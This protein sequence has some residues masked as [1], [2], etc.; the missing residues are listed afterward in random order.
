MM[1]YT[2]WYGTPLVYALYMRP[3]RVA[4][5]SVRRVRPA[6]AAA[7]GDLGKK[8]IRHSICAA[9]SNAQYGYDGWVL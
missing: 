2:S 5:M 3:A 1:M 8:P 4:S 9:P 7:I 6:Q